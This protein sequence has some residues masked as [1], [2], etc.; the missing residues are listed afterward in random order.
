MTF[1]KLVLSYTSKAVTTGEVKMQERYEELMRMLHYAHQMDDMELLQS[2]CQ[3]LTEIH[4]T[5]AVARNRRCYELL[6]EVEI[7]R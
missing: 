6:Q 7:G 5:T 2:I 3:E 4:L 1:Y